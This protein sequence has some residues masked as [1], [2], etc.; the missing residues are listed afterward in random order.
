MLEGSSAAE[1]LTL[2]QDVGG[3]NPPLPTFGSI[4]T[5][6]FCG[7]SEQG[8]YTASPASAAIA[9]LV[10]QLISNH[11]VGSSNLSSSTK[12]NRRFGRVC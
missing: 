8:Y 12:K 4:I 1:R 7:Y 9:Q 5:K 6:S 3:S 11:Q 2:N 10:E